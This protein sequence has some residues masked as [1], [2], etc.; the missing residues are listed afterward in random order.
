MVI[1]RT[2]TQTST[3]TSGCCVMVMTYRGNIHRGERLGR[4][5][6]INRQLAVGEGTALLP[7]KG[8]VPK[9]ESY[10]KSFTGQTRLV[11]QQDAVR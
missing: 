10:R 9:D 5:A 1:S 3:H 11:K 8:I 4:V 7:A 2:F 6:P